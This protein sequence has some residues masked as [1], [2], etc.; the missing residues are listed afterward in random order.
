MPDLC[1]DRA[2]SPTAVI[3]RLMSLFLLVS[4]SFL[5][6]FP[7]CLSLLLSLFNPNYSFLSLFRLVP[8]LTSCYNLPSRVVS[9][10][11]CFSLPSSLSIFGVSF[12]SSLPLC[13]SSLVSLFSSLASLFPNVYLLLCLSSSW[14]SLSRL[15]SL[16]SP[17][18]RVYLPSFLSPLV[19]LFS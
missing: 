13:I 2:A 7:S 15:S 19:S 6:L 12:L 18:F 17:F 16:E 14:H 11:P 4:L 9:L 3:D 1:Y 8:L 5:S 10:F